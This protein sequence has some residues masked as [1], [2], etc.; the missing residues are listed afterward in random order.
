MH[1]NPTFR[2]L[3]DAKNLEFAGERAFGTLSINADPA[4][5]LAHIPFLLDHESMAVELHLVRSNPIVRLL[6]T[7]QPAVI[8][9]TGP[10]SYIS[11]DWY[12]TPDLVPTWNYVAVHLRGTLSLL[13]QD[14]LAGIL[15]RLSHRFE[16][17]LSPKPIWTA[18]KVNPNALTKMMRMIVPLR[19]KIEQVHGTWKL[20]QNKPE[21]ARLTAAQA[22]ADTGIGQETKK[23]AAL[24][25][26]PPV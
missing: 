19:L 26:D 7:P 6:E 1:P 25:R 10:H 4:P 12:N 22:V 21:I 20:A 18:D 11:P 15:D 2:K 23:L 24:M 13:P 5:L 9:V 14:E 16:S 8:S 17:R 3:S